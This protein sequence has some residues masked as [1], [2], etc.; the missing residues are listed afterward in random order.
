MID[1]KSIVPQGTV[2]SN[3]TLSASNKDSRPAFEQVFF[4]EL[5]IK[6]VVNMVECSICHKK[7]D[8]KLAL[9]NTDKNGE[10]KVICQKCFKQETG[11]DYKT[12]AY[13]KE[14]AKQIAIAVII[15]LAMTVYTF[16]EKGP[17]YGILGIILTILIYFFA[18]K[19][20]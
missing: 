19:I 8:E 15:C 17:L 5:Q 11:V 1:S 20:K 16:C 10:K 6:K 9:V 4:V 13:R 7:I 18:G 14:N 12:F 2:G 3:P